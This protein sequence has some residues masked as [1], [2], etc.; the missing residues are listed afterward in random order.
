M[1][2]GP[3]GSGKSTLKSYLPRELLGVYLNP[4]EIEATIRK[5]GF[6]D[7][8]MF[9]ITATADR[10]L[11]FFATSQLLISA[12]L[13]EAAKKLDFSEGRLAFTNVPMNSYFAS[14]ASNF[15]QRSLLDQK[16]SFTL[17]TVMSHPSKVSLL[18]TAQTRGYRTYLY[19]VAT[20][21]PAINIARVKTRVALGGHS[22]PEDRITDRYYRSLGLLMEAIEHTNR[23]YI[24]DN[25]GEDRSGKH[26]WLAEITDA[27]LLELKSDRSPQWFHRSV[28][29]KTP[30]QEP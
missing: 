15:L 3:N 14:V 2:A 21:D 7:F 1:F 23:A 11:P 28:I 30:L 24:F 18:A 17:E 27:R 22:V 29:D 20:D 19:Y 6:L 25:S 12:G 8:S 26:V 13:K 10:V 9:G 4:D 5:D 16:T